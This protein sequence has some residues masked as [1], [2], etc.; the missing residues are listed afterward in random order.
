MRAPSWMA[1]WGIRLFTR[2]RSFE[3]D[4]PSTTNV[5]PF[6]SHKRGSQALVAARRDDETT[7]G[8]AGAAGGGAVA[9]SEEQIHAIETQYPEG[10]TAVQLVDAFTRNRVRFSEASFRKYVQQGLLPRSKRVGRKGKHKGSLGVYPAKTVRRINQ[11]K[12]LMADGYTI[13]EIQGQ[14][15]LYTD[16]VEGVA[17]NV[18]ELVTRLARDAERLEP[19]ARRDVAKELTEVRKEG[20][21]LVERLSAL[22]SRVS[23]PRT[24]NLRLAGAAGGAEDLF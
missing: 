22:A 14:V 10:L 17:E 18:T 11:V 24:D 7:G 6:R 4:A 8:G 16:L 1:H 2:D 15:L 19:T 9:L 21:R 13:E 5:V 3:P 23:A 20:D 12:R